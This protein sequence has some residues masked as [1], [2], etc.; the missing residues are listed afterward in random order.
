M[1]KSLK[2]INEEFR[3]RKKKK[4]K[5]ISKITPLDADF[6]AVEQAPAEPV[7]VTDAT[8]DEPKEGI[9]ADEQAPEPA[10]ALEDAPEVEDEVLT[11]V[12]SEPLPEGVVLQELELSLLYGSEL[13]AEME[14]EDSLKPE[15]ESLVG[16][17]LYRPRSLSEIEH[18]FKEKVGRGRRENAPKT[19]HHRRIASGISNFIY[20]ACAILLVI[21]AWNYAQNGRLFLGNYKMHNILTTSMQSVYPQGTLVFTKPV[22]PENLVVGNDIMFYRDATTT[23]FHRIVEIHEDFTGNNQRAFVTKG[24]DNERVD[25][26]ILPADNVIGKVVFFIPHV[27]KI[28]ENLR[29]QLPAV[30]I[31]LVSGILFSFFLSITFGET[32][33]ERK[34]RKAKAVL[35]D[36]AE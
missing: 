4:R 26:N 2:Q 23:V 28:S 9:S 10:E 11:D 36:S 5:K 33:K 15:P 3:N 22:D 6:T 21:V 20:Y 35:R 30:I 34:I 14:L 8:A 12:E 31:A 24:V 1:V 29:S 32:A 13:A 19:V 25:S 7:A 27:G 18:E 17:E 16:R